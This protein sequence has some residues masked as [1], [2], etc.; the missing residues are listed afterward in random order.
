M[1][2]PW[3]FSI[4]AAVYSIYRPRQRQRSCRVWSS[5]RDR[6]APIP[7]P[8]SRAR[9]RRAACS[10]L[11]GVVLSVLV[12][13]RGADAPFGLCSSRARPQP[14]ARGS[15]PSAPRRTTPP[16]MEAAARR[17]CTPPCMDPAQLEPQRPRCRRLQQAAL[18]GH[19]CAWLLSVA[20]RSERSAPAER[21]D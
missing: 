7:A 12:S 11:V 2:I 16:S 15:P 21:A 14:I 8:S 10:L 3:S 18:K 20:L 17:T 1:P 13:P 4:M 9:F 19:G 6:L 5:Q